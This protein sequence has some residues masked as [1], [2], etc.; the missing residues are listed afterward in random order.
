MEWVLQAADEFDDLLAVVRHGWLGLTAELGA[1]SLVGIGIGAALAGPALGA[2]PALIGAAAISA[3]VAA[4]LK[5]RG[6][7]MM[8]RA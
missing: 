2:E 5:I 1:L 8:R 4:L 6:S 7:R 3:N